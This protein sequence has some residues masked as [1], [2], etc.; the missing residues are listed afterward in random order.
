MTRLIDIDFVY[1]WLKAAIFEIA[2]KDRGSVFMR[3]DGRDELHIV[4]VDAGTFLELWKCSGEP[5]AQQ[6]QAEWLADYKIEG[7]NSGFAKGR[8][9]PVPLIHTSYF[10]GA[11]GQMQ[12][13]FGNGFTR[14]IWLLAHGADDFPVLCEPETADALHKAAGVFGHVPVSIGDLLKDLTRTAWLE[15]QPDLQ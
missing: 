2:T 3:A 1:G 12:I 7:A 13:G 5:L 11:S 15:R 8:G 6:T 9:D 10:R 14:T 4:V